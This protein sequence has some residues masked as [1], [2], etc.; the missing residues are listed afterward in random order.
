MEVSL[1]WQRVLVSVMAYLRRDFVEE[2]IDVRLWMEPN[3]FTV[4][5]FPDTAEGELHFSASSAGGD[6]DY[7]PC[8]QSQPIILSL[9]CT[10]LT[11]MTQPTNPNLL[12]HGHDMHKYAS[13]TC[14][15]RVHSVCCCTVN[16]NRCS[17]Y[18]YIYRSTI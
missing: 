2:M 12:G 1:A 16:V 11:G 3:I 13:V 17:L 4:Y 8:H 9:H 14:V 7:Q 5:C 10:Q 18:I 6:V 15:Y